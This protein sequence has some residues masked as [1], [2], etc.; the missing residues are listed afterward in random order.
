LWLSRDGVDWQPL[1]EQDALFEGFDYVQGEV[2]VG[3][4]VIIVDSGS[5]NGS[6]GWVGEL[7]EERAPGR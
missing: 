1:P 2:W 6:L 3:E 5:Y 7:V 4:D